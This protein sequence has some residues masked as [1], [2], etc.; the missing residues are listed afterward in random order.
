MPRTDAN[1]TAKPENNAVKHI[2]WKKSNSCIKCPKQSEY[3]ISPSIGDQKNHEK[4]IQ[5]CNNLKKS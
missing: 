5:I 1:F 4:R 2:S 3:V